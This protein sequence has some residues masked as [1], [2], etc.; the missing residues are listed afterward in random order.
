MDQNS[1]D[2]DKEFESNTPPEGCQHYVDLSD[3]PWDIQKYYYQR[4]SIFSQ[5]DEGI[6]MTEDAWFEVTPEPVAKKV[7]EHV[8]EA[9]PKSKAILI[10]CFAGVGGNVIAFARSGRWR[11]VY[12]IEKEP[13]A[14]ACAKHNAEIYG[15]QDQISW[16][17]GDCFQILLNELADLGEHSV[18][19][20]SPPWGGPGY[21]SDTVFDLT[22]MQPYTLLDL[23]NPLQKLANDVVLYLPRTSDMRQLAAQSKGSSKTMVFHYCMEGASK[24]ICAYFGAFTFR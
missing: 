18:V 16:Y 22:R 23:L 3:V 24:A 11:R 2:S 5:Y 1:Q 9:A 12:A 4:C 8:A 14:L 10:D 7:A 19:F 20:A 13:R 21:R 15:V 17:E 6:W